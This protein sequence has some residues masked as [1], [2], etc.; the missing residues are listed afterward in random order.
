MYVQL[1]QTG[2][3]IEP[4]RDLKLQSCNPLQKLNSRDIS[5]GDPVSLPTIFV[6]F[7]KLAGRSGRPNQERGEITKPNCLHVLN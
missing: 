6:K 2:L 5:F 1:D 7:C 4:P 3:Q